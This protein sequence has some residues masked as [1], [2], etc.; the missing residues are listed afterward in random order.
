METIDSIREEDI[1]LSL[2]REIPLSYAKNNVVMPL[3]REDGFFRA[4]VAD[5]RGLFALLEVAK[6]YGLKPAPVKARQGVIVDAINR[7]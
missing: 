4:A 3:K 6:R 1:D 2:I 5:D 7:F